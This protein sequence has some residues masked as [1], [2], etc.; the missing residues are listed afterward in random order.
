VIPTGD[1]S[2]PELVV[3]DDG[4]IPAEQ[5]RRLGLQPGD[6]L[7]VV[8]AAQEPPSGSLE[9]SLPDFPEL[10]WEDFERASEVARQDA[11]ISCE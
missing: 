3:A 8:E 10:N 4:S 9:G 6:H 1:A 2:G 7:R 5:L 11:A